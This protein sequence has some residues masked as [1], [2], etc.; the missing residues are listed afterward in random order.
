MCSQRDKK[1]NGWANQVG[2]QRKEHTPRSVHAA[3]IGGWSWRCGNGFYF[4]VIRIRTKFD[5]G[6]Y[7][8]WA[9]LLKVAAWLTGRIVLQEVVQCV[10]GVFGLSL[11][12]VYQ[13]RLNN[14][15]SIIFLAATMDDD[16]TSIPPGVVNSGRIEDKD[17]K[18]IPL[19]ALNRGVNSLHGKMHHET[20]NEPT[21]GGHQ[22]QSSAAHDATAFRDNSLGHS[23]SR[24][25]RIMP[26]TS[27]D[28]P[29]PAGSSASS[30]SNHL[31]P[32]YDP[33]VS[34]F[35]S[36]PRHQP[37]LARSD[38]Q[39]SSSTNI[40][41]RIFT[42]PASGGGTSPG[43]GSGPHSSQE[44]QLLQLSQIAA[45][46]ERIPENAMD[47]IGNGN[48]ASSRKRMA[49]GVVKHTRDKSIASPRQMQFGGHSRNTSTVSIASTA[50]SRV[51]EL[52]A[53][54]KARLSYAMV[55]VNRGWQSHSIDQVETLAS[56]AASQAASP[57]SS[58]S[59]V[60]LR[61]GSSASPQ[62][63][64]S[65]RA[66]NNTTPATGPKQQTPG[67]FADHL[68]RESPNTV[69]RGGSTSPIK[70][71]APALAP[72]VFIQPSQHYIHPRR[73]S[74]PRLTPSLLSASHQASSYPGPMSPGHTPGFL[75]AHHRASLGDAMAFSPHQNNAEKDAI[76]SLLFM[77]SPGNSANL[78]HAFPS[79]SQPLPS[80]HLAPQRTALPTGR[81]S[82]P[83]GRPTHARSQS[84]VQKRV[85]FEQSP[86]G[87]DIDEPQGASR[88]TPRRR[89]NGSNT[90]FQPPRLKHMPVSAGLAVPW[91]PRPVLADADIDRMLDRAAAA[92]D[93]DSEGE[94][95]LPVRK[96]RRDGAQPVV[97]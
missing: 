78:K 1:T 7:V 38:S 70:I 93:S 53:E 56:Q 20:H 92:A 35:P 88:G 75:A 52:S 72:P 74:N 68:G 80:S 11:C 44:S 87:M 43:T 66:S 61:N 77:S 83:S 26:G 37:T 33:R 89:T 21:E 29:L 54:L 32:T 13:G 63:S 71:A 76:E 12:G 23:Q 59:T 82:L 17:P 60:H 8:A 14:I 5:L 94:I 86:G 31:Q 3:A 25:D 19:S 9:Q 95:Q 15:A 90:E 2:G 73:H 45:A 16:P 10:H 49:D 30:S 96:A 62:L 84:Q 69:S 4:A 91:K 48:G 97:A 6:N 79:L 65:H 57:T 81:K 85:G 24:R 46:Q 55:K 42:P 39:E 27:T 41:D 22:I 67:R 58:T 28:I 40:T 47:G 18:T 51:G 50:G 34:Q 64:A 36:I